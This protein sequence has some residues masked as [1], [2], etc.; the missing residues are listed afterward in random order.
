MPRKKGLVST[1]RTI[2]DVLKLATGKNLSGILASSI[3]LFGQEVL[4]KMPANT[5]DPEEIARQMPYVVLG[6]NP[7]CPDFVLKAAYKVTMKE[8][9]PDTYKPDSDKAAKVN[10]AYE[11]ICKERGIPK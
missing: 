1:L 10:N 3:E 7:D 11:A 5:V 8:C 4:R 9:H 2:D 6:V